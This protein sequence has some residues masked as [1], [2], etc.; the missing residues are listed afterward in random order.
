MRTCHLACRINLGETRYTDPRK[1]RALV[2][3]LK[4]R[5]VCGLARVDGA[6]QVSRPRE[7]CSRILASEDPVPDPVEQLGSKKVQG[8]SWVMGIRVYG[9]DGEGEV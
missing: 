4:S 8:I 5:L 3:I 2:A 6:V 7:S 9:G 1:S